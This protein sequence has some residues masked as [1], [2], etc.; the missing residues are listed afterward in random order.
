MDMK[1][2]D[3]DGTKLVCL[4]SGGG[5]RPVAFV[6]GWCCDRSFFEPQLEY[7]A[8]A[9]RRVIAYRMHSSSPWFAD[10]TC[11]TV[12]LLPRKLGGERDRIDQSAVAQHGDLHS[13]P[14]RVAEQTLLK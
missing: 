11:S 5:G 10:R 2:L 13:L 6:H 1:T 3:R 7:F 12:W 9:G 14:D 4:D 8:N